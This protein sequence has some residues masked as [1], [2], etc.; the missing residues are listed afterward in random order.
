MLPSDSRGWQMQTMYLLLL[1]MHIAWTR[2][3]WEPRGAENRVDMIQTV[4]FDQ[5]TECYSTILW[6]ISEAPLQTGF[7]V[8]KVDS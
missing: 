5:E 7:S 1:F 2:K 3:V 6:F 8:T 4:S